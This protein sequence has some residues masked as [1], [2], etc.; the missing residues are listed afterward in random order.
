MPSEHDVGFKPSSV[1]PFDNMHAPGLRKR[2]ATAQELPKESCT[3]EEFSRQDIA[4]PA[5]SDTAHTRTPDASMARSVSWARSLDADLGE[6]SELR[7]E[8]SSPALPT[9]ASTKATVS[10]GVYNVR[11]ASPGSGRAP[12]SRRHTDLAETPLARFEVAADGKHARA[13]DGAALQATGALM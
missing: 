1:E 4:S 8:A 9:L 2:A 6:A 3:F 5:H 10:D 7:Q 13:D 12:Q 11:E